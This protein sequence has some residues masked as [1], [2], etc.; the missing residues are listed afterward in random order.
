MKPRL[1]P[2]LCNSQTYFP[3]HDQN[4]GNCQQSLLTIGPVFLSYIWAY[5][6]WLRAETHLVSTKWVYKY[7]F[8]IPKLLHVFSLPVWM[9]GNTYWSVLFLSCGFETIPTLWMSND[10]L[11]I[12]MGHAG[13][14]DSLWFFLTSPALSVDVINR[15]H[16]H[17]TSL[18]GNLTL[19]VMFLSPL[20][21]SQST[22]CFCCLTQQSMESV[23][24][25]REAR[26][27][28]VSPSQSCNCYSPFY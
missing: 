4:R 2:C 16:Q 5:R 6:P 22:V 26:C 10:S 19:I 27:K 28:C 11:P 12:S 15:K 23:M 1:Y 7:P 18:R 8:D 14:T 25:N 24:P 20:P 13:H 17:V 21:D 3:R 9:D